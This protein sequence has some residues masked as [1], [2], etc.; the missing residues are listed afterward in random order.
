MRL[1]TFELLQVARMNIGSLGEQ[2]LGHAAARPQ[3]GKI[4]AKDRQGRG[5]ILQSEVPSSIGEATKTDHARNG[6]GFN[7]ASLTP[8]RRNPRS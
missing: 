8:L 2:L 1:P 3:L 4:A 7:L 6:R 5:D